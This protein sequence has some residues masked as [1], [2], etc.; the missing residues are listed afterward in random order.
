MEKEFV[1]Y[2]L[3][4]RMKALGFDEPC[5]HLDGLGKVSYAEFGYGATPIPLYSQ[6]FRWFRDKYMIIG[7]LRFNENVKGEW[8]GHLYGHF[9]T[10]GVFSFG[11]TELYKT[12]E[13][14]ELACLERLIE[15]VES[16]SE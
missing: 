8:C 15:I 1:P 11:Y 16:K 3:A 10:H 14:A 2:K 13:K 12:Y 5:F 9:E 4:L 6:A 7:L